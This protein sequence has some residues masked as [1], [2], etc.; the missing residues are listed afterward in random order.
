MYNHRLFHVVALTGDNTTINGALVSSVRLIFKENY[1]HCYSLAAEQFMSN[2]D[3][4]IDKV[5][6]VD[7]KSNLYYCVRIAA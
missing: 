7:E 5:Q 2:H 3:A 6:K 4:F 1:S